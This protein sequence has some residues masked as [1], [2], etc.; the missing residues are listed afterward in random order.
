MEKNLPE[1]PLIEVSVCMGTNCAFRGACQLMEVL[2]LEE[3]IRNHCIILETSCMEEMCDHSRNSPV[4]K[5]G[6]DY[7]Q[8]AQPEAVLEEIYSRMEM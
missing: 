2:K 7:Y 1:Q 6:N 8:K 5:I 3:G 4:V